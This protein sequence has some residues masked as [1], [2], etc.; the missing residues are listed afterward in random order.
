MSRKNAVPQ[1]LEDWMKKLFLFAL[2]FTALVVTG[3][4]ASSGGGGEEA[5]PTPVPQEYMSIEGVYN[6]EGVGTTNQ[7]CGVY[8]TASEVTFWAAGTVVFLQGED[9]DGTLNK[10]VTY[11]DGWN[12]VNGTLDYAGNFS[13]DSSADED[14]FAATSYSGVF[15]AGDD[16]SAAYYRGVKH[17][18]IPAEW[19]CGAPTEGCTRDVSLEGWKDYYHSPN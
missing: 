18:D 12:P 17:S 7:W 4:A 10:N 9:E 3:C 8:G 6:L 15:S 11:V 14:P 19:C 16:G 1:K 2:A 5:T 13:V